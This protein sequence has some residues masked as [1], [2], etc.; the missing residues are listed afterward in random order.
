MSATP[1]HRAP[2]HP[3]EG[4]KPFTDDTVIGPRELRAWRTVPGEA[5]VQTRCSRHTR[6]P[7]HCDDRRAAVG[8]FDGYLPNSD[9][10]NPRRQ[11]PSR[12]LQ[13]APERILRMPPDPTQTAFPAARSDFDA[14]A[15]VKTAVRNGKAVPA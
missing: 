2:D 1:R 4:G 14:V 5:W 3:Q 6:R 7:S 10:P 9:L 15:R 11:R 8:A 12:R 13:T